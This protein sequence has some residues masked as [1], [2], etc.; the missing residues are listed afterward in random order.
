MDERKGIKQD[1]CVQVLSFKRFSL[2]KRRK[3]NSC[4]QGLTIIL[5][6][7]QKMKSYTFIDT[8]QSFP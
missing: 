7:E 8:E 4:M 1:G 2:M 5:C 6:L 3:A